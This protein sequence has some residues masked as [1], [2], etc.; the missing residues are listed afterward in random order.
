TKLGLTLQCLPT[1][2]YHPSLPLSFYHPSLPLSFYHPSLPLSFT[3][4]PPFLLLPP[5]QIDSQFVSIN[6]PSGRTRICFLFLSFTHTHTRTHTHTHTHTHTY[7]VMCSTS[8]F[9]RSVN[10]SWR[11]GICHMLIGSY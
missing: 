5:S 4:I 9:G 7:S 8:M 1:L 6:V 11:E 2:F 10:I 3:L